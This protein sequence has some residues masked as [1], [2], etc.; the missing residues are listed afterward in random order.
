MFGKPA[1]DGERLRS[2]LAQ[3]VLDPVDWSGLRSDLGP[4]G[5]GSEYTQFIQHFTA[6]HLAARLVLVARGFSERG[7][8][9]PRLTSDPLVADSL[10]SYL[11]GSTDLQAAH[12][13]DV[14]RLTLS[15]LDASRETIGKGRRRALKSWSKTHHPHC[16]ICGTPLDYSKRQTLITYTLEHIWPQHLGGNS[17]DDNLLPACNLCNSGRKRDAVSWSSPA[18]LSLTMKPSPS[19]SSLQ[20]VDGTIKFALL[21]RAAYRLADKRH[22]TLK[23]AFLELGPWTELRILDGDDAT[24][25]FNVENHSP[26]ALL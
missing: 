17:N 7:V 6:S 8:A 15:S 2:F 19:R 1:T 14:V 18:I 16:F 5:R 23:E 22:C 12:Y 24:D 9:S 11:I 21:Y 13:D 20:G 4:T 25:F 26:S 10:R 3:D